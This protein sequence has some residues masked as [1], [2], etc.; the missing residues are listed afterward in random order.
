L[1]RTIHKRHHR[2][3]LFI[4]TSETVFWVSPAK[5]GAPEQWCEWIRGHCQIE[6]ASHNVRDVAFAE[7][8]SCIRKNPDVVGRLRS[9]AYN[10]IRA[11]GDDNIQNARYHAALDLAAAIK[12]ATQ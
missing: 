9:F 2:T 8:A 10:A 1:K 11:S 4:K 6:S 12:I 3:G 5:G 7:D